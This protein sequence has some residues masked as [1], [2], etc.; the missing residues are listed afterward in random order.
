MTEGSGLLRSWMLLR[1][2]LGYV[3]PRVHNQ[4]GEG[5]RS[6]CG[7]P[8][9]I[10]RNLVGWRSKN[11]YIAPPKVWRTQGGSIWKLQIIWGS[12]CKTANCKLQIILNILRTDMWGTRKQCQSEA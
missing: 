12:I 4:R 10:Y 9:T 2:V 1:R 11:G 3:G 6:R 7:Q 8:Q 5:N